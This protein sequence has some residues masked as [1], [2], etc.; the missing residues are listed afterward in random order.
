MKDTAPKVGQYLYADGTITASVYIGKDN[1]VG[2][3][4]FE[5]GK[6]V[7]QDVRNGRISGQWPA[8]KYVFTYGFA[9]NGNLVLSAQFSDS[10][11]FTALV[12]AND[13][14][15]NLP[16]SMQFH[17][18]DAVLDINGDGILDSMQNL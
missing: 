16:Y 14:K 17:R 8:Y 5:N 9:N 3:T 1:A 11:A 18:D 2:I 7:Y 15:L 10:R 4:V 12:E 6:Y 13:N